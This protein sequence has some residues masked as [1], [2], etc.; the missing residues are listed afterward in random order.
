MEFK[1]QNGETYYIQ[2]NNSEDNRDNIS[3]SS[4]DDDSSTDENEIKQFFLNQMKQNQDNNQ[5]K[6][7]EL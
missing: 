2:D 1:T 4:S 6:I 7:K 3:S 5:N